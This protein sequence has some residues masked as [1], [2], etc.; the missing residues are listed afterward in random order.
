MKEWSMLVVVTQ[1]GLSVA[2]PLAGF[3]L[4]SL[5]LKSRFHLGAWVVLLGVALGLVS[6]VDGLLRT[7]KMMEGMD[8]RKEKGDPPPTSFNNHE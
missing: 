2:A 1:L 3:T 5:W 6:A 7:L 4:L 8:K